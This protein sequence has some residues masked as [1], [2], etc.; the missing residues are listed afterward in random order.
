MVIALGAAAVVF[1]VYLFLIAPGRKRKAAWPSGMFDVPYAHRGLHGEGVPENSLPAFAAA[2]AMG[3][4][5]EMDVHL[6]GDGCL[7]IHHDS[8]LKTSCGADVIIEKTPLAQLRQYRLFGTEETIPTL[9]EA[10]ERIGGHTPLIVEMKTAGK[11][12]GELARKTLEVLRG[13]GG[14]WCVESFDPRLMAFVRRH[15]PDVIRGQLAFDPW[16]GNWPQRG[17]KYF[18]GAHMLSNF[19]SRPDFIAYDYET[20]RNFTF[21]LIRTLFRPVTA[22]WT[23]RSKEAWLEQRNR[24][25]LLIFEGFR[26]NRQR[27]Q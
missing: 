5:I 18:C 10:L 14:L 6:T 27:D 19:L 8:S 22:A 4:G 15:A 16:K 2:A 17:A 25:D 11:R 13:A 24:Y 3:Y 7:V 26:P 12:N 23:V 1:G 9:E 20:D 21:R